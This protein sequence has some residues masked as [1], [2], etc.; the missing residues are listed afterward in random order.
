MRLPL[1]LVTA[2]AVPIAACAL[3][4]PTAGAGRA[5]ACPQHR[6]TS[7]YAG[8]VLRALRAKQDLWGNQLIARPNGPTYASVRRLLKPLLFA[9][10]L[11]KPLTASGIYYLPFAQPLGVRG[12]STVALHLAD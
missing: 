9:R 3:W 5:H 4:A 11:R 12:A 10:S 7:A 8:S 1:A 6:V 2:A